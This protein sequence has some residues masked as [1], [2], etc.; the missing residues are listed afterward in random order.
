[1]SILKITKADIQK[2]KALEPGWYGASVLRVSD[3]TPS[4]DKQ[5]NNIIVT[6]GLEGADG[7]EIPHYYNSKLIAMM[8]PMI[9]AV[10]N[11]KL[12]DDVDIDPSE[13]IGSKLD[14]KLVTEI[15]NGN[16]QN[17]IEGYLPY[18]QGKNQQAP[19]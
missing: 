6:F 15:Y 18:G 17:K 8:V 10:K 1:M 14:L 2:L 9:E 12:T 7:K 3:P 4:K 16:P 5:S 19:F 13:L 11:T